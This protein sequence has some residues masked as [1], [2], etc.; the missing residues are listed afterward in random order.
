MRRPVAITGLGAVTAYGPG[1]EVLF[2]GLLSGRAPLSPTPWGGQGMAAAWEPLPEHGTSSRLASLAVAE[3][4]D[5]REGD[6]ALLDGLAIIG[7]STSGDMRLGEEAWRIVLE[8][9]TPEDPLHYLWSQLCHQPTRTV[10]A[11]LGASG[12]CL[13][14]STACTSGACAIGLA[15]ELVASGQVEAALAFGADALCKITIHGFASL[16]ALAAGESHPFDRDRDGL[17]L[18]EGAGAVLLESEAR[19]RANGLRP[20]AWLSGYGNRADAWRLTA[21]HPEA[22]GAISAMRAA[23][24][25]TPASTV[26]LICAHGTGTPLNDAMEAVAFPAVLPGAAIVGVKGAIGHTLGAAGAIAAIVSILALER[27]VL[28][29]NIGLNEPEDPAL[30]LV[31][32]PRAAPLE[33]AMSVNFAF[34]G[35]DSALLFHRDR[36]VDLPQV[37]AAAARIAGAELWVAGGAHGLAA[38]L[39]AGRPRGEGQWWTA[40]DPPRPAAIDA[41]T[42][43]RMSRL[44]RMVATVALPLVAGLE[45]SERLGIVWGTAVG[46]LVPTSRFLERLFTEGPQAASPLAFQNSVYNAPVGHLSIA[47]NLPGPSETLAAGGA[48]GLAAL[49]RGAGMLATGEVD[50]VLVLAGDD[51]SP[52]LQTSYR[53]VGETL[54]V[55]EAVAAVLLRSDQGRSLRILPGRQPTDGPPLARA[56]PFPGESALVSI[57]GAVA[58]ERCLGLCPSLGLSLVAALAQAEGGT[59]IDQDDGHAFTAVVGGPT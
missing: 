24:G 34:G 7:A 21:P 44:A 53:L 46:E 38:D 54:P 40:A 4:L 15:A 2:D 41:G 8:G 49:W 20:R 56:A 36:P 58:P 42:W 22:R 33:A 10:R 11:N 26:G 18:G 51:I 27:G 32:S 45:G 48:T 50:A 57:P 55:G 17:N 6:R 31:R 19:V 23:L 52:T 9:G 1:A 13:T 14:I 28:P 35:H 12:P 43:R 16:G 25:N 37:P 5:G 47:L 39:F 3:A 29:A 30:D 59:V